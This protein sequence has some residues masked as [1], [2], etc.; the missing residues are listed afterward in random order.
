VKASESA[1]RI[2]I[3]D[4]SDV[5]RL[6]CRLL[7]Q[8][9]RRFK[10][11]DD[12][13]SLA[14]L[15]DQESPPDLV[16]FDPAGGGE[17]DGDLLP[18]LTLL[19]PSAGYLLFTDYNESGFVLSAF[20]AGARG[21][22]K[23]SCTTAEFLLDAAHHIGHKRGVI[24][25]RSAFD[26]LVQDLRVPLDDAPGPRIPPVALTPREKDVLSL[27]SAGLSDDQIARQLGLATTT[28]QTHVGNILNKSPAANRVQLGVFAY[29]TGLVDWKA[30]I[31]I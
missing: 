3:I 21:F 27:L 30:A 4:A 22:V 29:V 13:S 12:S 2:A 8:R 16:V 26:R 1:L 17:L 24:F 7:F 11:I 28:I 23:K 5:A 25:D 18:C 14:G 19:F 15:R 9:D 6:G 20:D 10:V 31:S